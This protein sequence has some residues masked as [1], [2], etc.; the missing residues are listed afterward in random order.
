MNTPTL[1]PTVIRC[2]ACR[3]KYVDRQGSDKLRLPEEDAARASGWIVWSGTTMGGRP[4]RQVFC[5]PCS[6]RSP[7]P[8]D[9]EPEAEQSWDAYCRTC[10]THASDEYGYEKPFTE[11]DAK[12]WRSDHR[13]E[14]DVEIV[15]PT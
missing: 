14:P 13:C 3:A 4:S 11:A 10:D 2:L 5:P 9:A 15:D 8:H 6:G 12:A 7:E 1:E